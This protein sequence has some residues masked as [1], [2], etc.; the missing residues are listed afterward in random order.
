MQHSNKYYLLTYLLTYLLNTLPS[1]YTSS[2]DR[3]ESVMRLEG[4]HR[5][6]LELHWFCI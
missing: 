1:H 3:A 4:S 5:V 2:V 6:R